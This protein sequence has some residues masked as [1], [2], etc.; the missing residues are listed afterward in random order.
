MRQLNLRQCTNMEKSRKI[1]NGVVQFSNGEM[2]QFSIATLLARVMNEQFHHADSWRNPH[3]EILSLE[4]QIHVKPLC[5]R[6]KIDIYKPEPPYLRIACH[7]SA[8]FIR[9][10]GTSCCSSIMFVDQILMLKLL[11][12]C[13]SPQKRC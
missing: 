6:V 2:I 5:L 7:C 3:A 1:P 9:I 8:S 4:N 13:K 10:P 11:H 12:S